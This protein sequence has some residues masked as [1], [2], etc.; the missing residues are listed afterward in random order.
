MT[1]KRYRYSRCNHLKNKGI[2]R[3]TG[4]K[5]YIADNESGVSDESQASVY[6]TLI[7]QL[8]N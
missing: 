7:K 1:M 3:R 2:L 5:E 4:L 6:L 8:L